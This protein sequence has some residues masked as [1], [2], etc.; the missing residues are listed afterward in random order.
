MTA[1]THGDFCYL[2]QHCHFSRI[3][4]LYL[5]SCML[6]TTKYQTHI[7]TRPE[8]DI[9]ASWIMDSF[10]KGKELYNLSEP[11]IIFK[12]GLQVENSVVNSIGW[13][14]DVLSIATPSIWK[15]L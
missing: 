6:D 14:A 2:N 1:T 15:Q 7:L 11:R 5:K 8:V 13:K 4:M 10:M 9:A 12:T 3:E